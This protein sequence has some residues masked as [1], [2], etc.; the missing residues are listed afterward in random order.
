MMRLLPLSP[1][2]RNTSY[3]LGV[4]LAAS[5]C[6]P[7]SLTTRPADNPLLG[8][9]AL[10]ELACTGNVRSSTVTCQPAAPT[11]TLAA[12]TALLAGQGLDVRKRVLGGQDVNVRLTSSNVAYNAGTEVFQF[13]VTIQNLL[14]EA[15]GSINGVTPDAGGIKVFFYQA[16]TATSGTGVISI[17][18]KDGTGTF[19]GANQDYYSYTGILAK[20]EVTAAKTWQFSVPATVNTF[21]FTVYLETTVQA[22]LVINELLT[23]PGGTITDAN[24]EWFEVY[25]AGS[26][27]V[28]MQG[29]LIADSASSGR[30]PYHLITSS[31]IVP[32][33]GYVVL[34]NTTNTTLNGGVPVD[35]AYGSALTIANAQD[36]IKISYPVAGDTVTIDYVRFLSVNSAKNGISRELLNPSLDNL[37]IDGSNWADAMDDA[38]YG[39]GGR[40]T[41]KAQNQ[42]V[43]P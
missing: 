43:S 28:N 36:A 8:S 42:T 20:D 3:L 10:V 22:M 2:T 15:L 6:S 30:R 9:N 13:D 7:D 1:Y 12:R 5:A 14:N 21:S 35:Y 17:L 24:G 16:P 19:N 18:N 11:R 37:D 25:N 39:P 23:N 34:G 31:L 29:F 33:G 38:V 26:L 27:S 4:I 32:P 40:G 41:P